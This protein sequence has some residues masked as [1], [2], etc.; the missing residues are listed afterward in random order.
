MRRQLLQASIQ[1]VKTHGWSRNAICA[2]AVSLGYSPALSGLVSSGEGELVD[3][4]MREGN[5]EMLRQV[6]SMPLEDMGVTDT[7]KCAIKARLMYM[8]PYIDTWPQAMSIGLMPTNLPTTLTSIALLSDDIWHR[9]GDRS[10]DITWY[11]KRGLIGGVYV[12]TEL[13]MLTDKSEGFA[14]TWDFLERRL[15]DVFVIGGAMKNS[16]GLLNTVSTGLVSQPPSH[17]NHQY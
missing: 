4:F 6:R 12:S 15:Q 16:E 2:G 9:V 1:H 7:I 10:T 14:N 5:E 11:T 13:Y 3:F 17:C 8:A